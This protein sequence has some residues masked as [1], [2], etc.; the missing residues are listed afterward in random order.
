MPV[1]EPHRHAWPLC[2][3]SVTNKIG[4]ITMLYR[5]FVTP[6]SKLSSLSDS[7][8][9]KIL[10]WKLRKRI[11]E[12][13]ILVS[14]KVSWTW[15][16]SKQG[17]KSTANDIWHLCHFQKYIWAP[18]LLLGV[19]AGGNTFAWMVD[20]PQGQAFLDA[21]PLFKIFSDYGQYCQR[22]SGCA[23]KW[24]SGEHPKTYTNPILCFWQPRLRLPKLRKILWLI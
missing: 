4:D 20:L 19:W 10:A 1:N 13:G 6:P 16:C 11:G 24:P 2:L 7:L 5:L 23:F 15:P 12:P 21:N 9:K 22:R 14:I 17:T 3:D 18:L 8:V